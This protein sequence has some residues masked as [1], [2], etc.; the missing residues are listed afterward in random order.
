MM[1]Y[2]HR[3]SAALLA[4]QRGFRGIKRGFLLWKLYLRE[5]R[6]L[7]RGTIPKENRTPDW[8]YRSFAFLSWFLRPPSRTKLPMTQKYSSPQQRWLLLDEVNAADIQS[9]V[10]TQCAGAAREKLN[11]PTKPAAT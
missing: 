6:V 9:V 8:F 4:L 11:E 7:F 2:V 1:A 3:R 5:N 10:L